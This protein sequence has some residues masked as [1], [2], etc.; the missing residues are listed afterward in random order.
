[1]FHLD[2]CGHS[3]PHTKDFQPFTI[4]CSEQCP[5]I[6][7]KNC[8]SSAKFDDELLTWLCNPNLISYCNPHNTNQN[9]D[10]L[11]S[12]ASFLTL[13]SP[14]KCLMDTDFKIQFALDPLSHVLLKRRLR[15][16]HGVRLDKLVRLNE[17]LFNQLQF[18]YW[19]LNPWSR[20]CLFRIRVYSS[21]HNQA[22]FWDNINMVT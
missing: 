20:Q 17:G 7:L 18:L 21:H 22:K 12:H 11:A 16:A 19:E 13:T 1:M 4:N 9:S 2:S 5:T 14:D 8:L 3:I 10:G 15:P 6:L